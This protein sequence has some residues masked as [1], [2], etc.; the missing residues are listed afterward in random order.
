MIFPGMNDAR[1]DSEMI[2][3]ILAGDREMFRAL[4]DKYSDG[5][6]RFCRVRLGNDDEAEDAVQ[7]VFIRAFRSLGS[8]KLG[9]SFPAW[10]FTIAANRV[11]TKYHAKVRDSKLTD[12]MKREAHMAMIPDSE[13]EALDSLAAERL[14]AALGKL[15]ENFRVPLELFYFTGLSVHDASLVL[16]IGT[17]A[18]KSRLFRARKHLGAIMED[19][20]QPGSFMEGR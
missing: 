9:L 17:E 7:D 18:F 19:S 15:P 5:L 2:Q 11:K 12:A 14:R 20:L 6:F 10:L 16:G 3:K 8:F 4:V 13:A 1:N